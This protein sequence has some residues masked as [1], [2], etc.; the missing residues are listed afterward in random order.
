M[1]MEKI[2]LLLQGPKVYTAAG[3]EASGAREYDYDFDI[4]TEVRD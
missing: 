4:R 2:K 3:G 1:T